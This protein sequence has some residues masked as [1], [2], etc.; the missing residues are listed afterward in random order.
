MM[1]VVMCFNKTQ[2]ELEEQYFVSREEEIED[3]KDEI[4]DLQFMFEMHQDLFSKE[5]DNWNKRMIRCYN[6]NLINKKRELHEAIV[7]LNELHEAI[8]EL[9]E[10]I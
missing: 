2:K 10:H 6:I 9:N 5:G 8:V 7:E 1:E 4:I 3:L